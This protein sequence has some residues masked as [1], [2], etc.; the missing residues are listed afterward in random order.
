MWCCR[1]RLKWISARG[2]GLLGLASV[3]LCALMF[4]VGGCSAFGAASSI[5]FPNIRAARP[6]ASKGMS[7]P[8][9]RAARP[10]AL[11]S[12][13]CATQAQVFSSEVTEYLKE[14]GLDDSSIL[15][16]SQALPKPTATCIRVNLLR[17][18]VSDVAESLRDLCKKELG[19]S[20]TLYQ[21]PALPEVESRTVT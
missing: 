7:F 2:E 19:Y 4:P 14:N 11:K 9:I 1:K 8:N 6:R 20:P 16:F 21:H 15:K 3:L 10:R 17:T 13:L 18:T 5:S 12:R